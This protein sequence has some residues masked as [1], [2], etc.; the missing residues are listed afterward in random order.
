MIS[1]H[2]T[3]GAEI[4]DHSL[5]NTASEGSKKVS[6]YLKPKIFNLV[7]WTWLVIVVAVNLSCCLGINFASDHTYQQYNDIQKV[8]S[9][10]SGQWSPTGPPLNMAFGRLLL[11]ENHL[12]VACGTVSRAMG[13][14]YS[15][16]VGFG[17]VIA[18]VCCLR[19]L[20]E[21]SKSAVFLIV[22]TVEVLYVHSLV[23]SA[24]DLSSSPN[25]SEA[26]IGL[27]GQH[28]AQQTWFCVTRNNHQKRHHRSYI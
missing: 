12:L 28:W 11:L 4:R 26:G 27:S 13:H 18:V 24:H 20:L 10:A 17:L 5:C 14:W 7:C 6:R 9:E 22:S 8:L 2:S 3:T 1:N 19:L 21:I 15:S 23:P 25:V 16:W